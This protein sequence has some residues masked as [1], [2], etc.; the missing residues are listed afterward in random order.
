MKWFNVIDHFVKLA[1]H[2]SNLTLQDSQDMYLSSVC[3]ETKWLTIFWK[4]D[5]VGDETSVWWVT[6][7]GH[8]RHH[9]SRKS[10]NLGI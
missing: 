7:F 5:V 8:P 10:Q 1:S 9:W 6:S 2:V 3:R 4:T